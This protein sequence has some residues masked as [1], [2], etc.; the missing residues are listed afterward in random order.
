MTTGAPA[1]SVGRAGGR[2][3]A[4]YKSL[5]QVWWR[6]MRRRVV[7]ALLIFLVVLVAPLLFLAVQTHKSAWWFDAGVM[8]GAAMAFWLAAKDSPPEHIERWRTGFQ[9]EQ[10]T[11]KALKKM[12]SEWTVLHDLDAGKRGN[13]DHVLVGPGGVF[14]LDSKLFVGRTAIEDGI[15]RVR[16]YEDPDLSYVADGLPQ[17][18]RALARQVHDQVKVAAKVSVWVQ[19]LVVLW[20]EFDAGEIDDTGVTYL[21][22]SRLREWVLGQPQRLPNT[23]VERVLR[24]VA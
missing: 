12:P 6:R 16:R 19:P 2:A 18:M 3:E 10:L 9:G 1:R 15:V 13:L 24:A 11:A 20:G 21:H 4:R 7:L 23:G 17:R 8:V 22:G 14:L 5:Q